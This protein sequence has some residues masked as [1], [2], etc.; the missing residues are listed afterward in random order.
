MEFSKAFNTDIHYEIFTGCVQD[1]RGYVLFAYG[2]DGTG[3]AYCKN[4][5]LYVPVHITENIFNWSGKSDYI[6]KVELRG[7]FLVCDG[8]II[9]HTSGI[10]TGFTIPYD[11][12]ILGVSRPS[13]EVLVLY[14]EDTYSLYHI[15]GVSYINTDNMSMVGG[16]VFTRE[17]DHYICVDDLF[18]VAYDI[19][20]DSLRTYPFSPVP[21]RPEPL[22][23]IQRRFVDNH[24]F[25]QSD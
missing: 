14:R 4:T 11:E 17:A 21:L 10:C 25:Q 23:P 8:Y 1:P 5:D 13:R 2:E 12:T 18:A 3:I 22:T 20:A 16:V 15:D 24:G 7:D 9:A 19:D 6:A